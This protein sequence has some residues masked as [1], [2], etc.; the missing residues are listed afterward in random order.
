[1]PVRVVAWRPLIGQERE[2][3]R[4]PAAC[5]PQGVFVTGWTQP[6]SAFLDLNASFGQVGSACPDGQWLL[7]ITKSAV[8]LG[9]DLW[10]LDLHSRTTKLLL[11][12][13]PLSQ[14][15]VSWVSDFAIVS[16]YGRAVRVDL[17]SRTA[18]LVSL[19]CRGGEKR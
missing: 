15:H 14:V 3:A 17:P 18:R 4:L 7:F 13:E 11:A 12:N 9:S 6:L 19:P 8:G 5:G 10:L 2:L 1:L 16:G